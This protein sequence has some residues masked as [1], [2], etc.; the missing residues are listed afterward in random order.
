[1][2][3][4]FGY[5]ADFM[6]GWDVDFLQAAVN[7]CTNDSGKIEDCPHFTLQSEDAQKQC[8]MRLPSVLANEK[9][10]GVVGNVLPGNVKIQYGPGPATVTNP[11]P[12]TTVVAVPTVSYSEGTKPTDSVY[13]PGQ[14]FKE[15]SSST[16]AS[17]APSSTEEIAALA[18]P[19][20]TPAPE[21]PAPTPVDDGYEIIRTDYVTEG[22]LVNMI[23]VKEKIEYVTVTTTTYTSTTTIGA[24]KARH[25]RHMHRHGRR[26]VRH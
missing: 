17:E 13:Q 21:P 26:H 18:Q 7:D 12:Q 19:P 11:G 8:E 5:H 4:G 20:V 10:A 3:V 22:N 2:A 1:M 23:I 16:T 9:V 14:M 15:I 24:L 25:E 6:T